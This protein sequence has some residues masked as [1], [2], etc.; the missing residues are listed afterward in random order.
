MQCILKTKNQSCIQPKSLNEVEGWCHCWCREVIVY[1]GEK[2]I[3]VVL[4]C[5]KHTNCTQIIGENIIKL[6]P[7]Q[8]QNMHLC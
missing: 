2:R 1:E 7:K 4:K 3:R 5:S 6:Y 8:P